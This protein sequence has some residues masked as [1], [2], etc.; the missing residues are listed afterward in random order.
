MCPK[1]FPSITSRQPSKGVSDYQFVREYMLIPTI[2]SLVNIENGTQVLDV[3]CGDG[4]IAIKLAKMGANVVAIDSHAESLEY[5]KK[6]RA[7]KNIQYVECD[8]FNCN[9]PNKFDISILSL[10]LNEVTDYK[11]LIEKI[12]FKTQ[13]LL[14]IIPH[15]CFQFC[16]AQWVAMKK[17]TFDNQA[18]VYD[19][20]RYIKYNKFQKQLPNGRVVWEYH[21]PL[22][23]Y[24]NVL[25]ENK[26]CIERVEEPLL[27][28]ESSDF[29]SPTFNH[30]YFIPKFIFIL[31]KGVDC[32]NR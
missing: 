26:F 7:H 14:I 3:G 25:A 32:E 13:R 11:T 19:V 18:L 21:R 4:A 17:I 31:A 2:A 15:P 9:L 24:F 29:H 30:A 27:S 12:A 1:A 5:A 22:S 20:D 23:E 16:Y 8:I 28:K 6:N 10:V